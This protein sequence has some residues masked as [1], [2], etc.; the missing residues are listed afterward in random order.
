[1]RN[2]GTASLIWGDDYEFRQ[3]EDVPSCTTAF[4][5]IPNP[6]MGW[7][8]PLRYPGANKELKIAACIKEK[9]TKV[10]L[11][12]FADVNETATD[13]SDL[14]SCVA[15]DDRSNRVTWGTELRN[16]EDPWSTI[17]TNDHC[18]VISYGDFSTDQDY[19]MLVELEGD[20]KGVNEFFLEAIALDTVPQETEDNSSRASETPDKLWTT[21]LFFGVFFLWNR[22]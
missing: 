20:L 17:R 7:W 16:G 8:I 5:S 14:G 12:I 6:V 18:I 21:A 9:R 15:S 2:R 4:G 22:Q 10:H 11:S 13:C 1:M 3:F 19:Y